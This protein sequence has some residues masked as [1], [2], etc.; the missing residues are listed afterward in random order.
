MRESSVRKSRTEKGNANNFKWDRLK[1]GY[2][3]GYKIF[4]SELRKLIH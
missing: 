2:G 4:H 3:S 1:R